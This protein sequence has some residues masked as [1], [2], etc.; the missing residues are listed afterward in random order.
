MILSKEEIYNIVEY[1]SFIFNYK[2]ILTGS[3]ADFFNINYEF[4]QDFDFII[5]HDMY[6]SV[7]NKAKINKDDPLNTLTR[8]AS[9]KNINDGHLLHRYIYNTYQI[10]FMIKSQNMIDTDI[11]TIQLNN[12][13]ILVFGDNARLSQLHKY[14]YRDTTPELHV[15]YNNI[16]TRIEGYNRRLEKLNLRT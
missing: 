7:R 11:S 3:C 8:T 14:D 2:C 9:F 16:M 15:K 12:K 5:E 4:V 1:V 10:D 6:W 13:N